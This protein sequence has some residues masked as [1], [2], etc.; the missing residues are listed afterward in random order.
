MLTDQQ[1]LSKSTTSLGLTAPIGI[2]LC[3]RLARTTPFVGITF[4]EDETFPV[5]AL[6]TTAMFL[7]QQRRTGRVLEDLPDA[8]VCFG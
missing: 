3:L 5:L 2:P 4:L 1:P 8:V 7:A 6:S